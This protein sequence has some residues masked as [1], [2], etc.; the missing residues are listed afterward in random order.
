MNR[1][2]GIVGIDIGASNIKCALGLL[3]PG[4]LE[5]IDIIAATTLPT[6]GIK[7][8]AVLRKDLLFN[9]LQEGIERVKELSQCEIA[10]TIISVSSRYFYTLDTS[11]QIK[12]SEGR[13]THDDVLRVVKSCHDEA[14]QAQSSQSGYAITHTL[15]QSYFLDHELLTGQPW[16]KPGLHLELKSHLV[17]GHRETLNSIW[18]LERHLPAP[19]LDVVPDLLAQAEGLF[20]EDELPAEA[21]ILDIG[22]ETTKVLLFKKGRPFFLFSRFQGGIHLTNEIQKQL[23]ISD[24]DDAEQLKLRYGQVYIDAHERSER[25]IPLQTDGPI[26]YVRQETLAR[27]LERALTENLSALRV[28]LEEAGVASSLNQGVILTGGTANIPGI[29]ALAG[30]ILQTQ[31]TLGKPRQRGVS[32]LVFTPQYATVNGLI[33][34]GL[35]ERYDSWFSCWKRQLNQVPE[36]QILRANRSGFWERLRELVPRR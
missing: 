31:V 4:E 7:E 17:Y 23:K 15:P 24:F 25:R 32:D 27:I 26:R 8:G 16:S 11:G 21:A 14:A 6:M 22:S 3:V 36:P 1:E 29:C 33:I 28:R 20:R 13:V 18:E 2:R 10:N 35:R 5:Y 12:I 9:A 30:D 34:S 19:L